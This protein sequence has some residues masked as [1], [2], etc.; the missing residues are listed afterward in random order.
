MKSGRSCTVMLS[1]GSV[2]LPF[3]SCA[4]VSNAPSAPKTVAALMEQLATAVG[5]SVE[6]L[7]LRLCDT[8]VAMRSSSLDERTRTVQDASSTPP[9][10][11]PFLTLLPSRNWRSNDS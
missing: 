5:V 2:L 7:T 1:H 4:K 3:R 9:P 10:S 11:L 8:S 6:I